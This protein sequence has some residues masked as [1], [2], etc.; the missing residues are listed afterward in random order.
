MRIFIF[1]SLSFSLVSL[2]VASRFPL[3]GQAPRLPGIPDAA[4]RE[5]GPSL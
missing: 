4:G 3:L 1:L 5:R 2:P